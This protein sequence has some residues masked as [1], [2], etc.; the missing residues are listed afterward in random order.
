MRGIVQV[1]GILLLGLAIGCARHEQKSQPSQQGQGAPGSEVSQKTAEQP[2]KG[3]E[4]KAEAV[5]RVKQWQPA[6]GGSIMLTRGVSMKMING[7]LT[8]LEA[9]A[10]F[11]LAVIRLSVTRLAEGATL[12]LD[13]VSVYDDK[14]KKYVSAVGGLPALGKEANESREFAFA[15]PIRTPL[16]KIELAKGVSIDLK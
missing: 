7:S 8:G 14:G 11:E 15:V 5:R 12:P 4:I 13:N 10:G 16:K 2:A 6:E 9:E 3:F 1:T